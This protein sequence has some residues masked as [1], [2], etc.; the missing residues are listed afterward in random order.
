MSVADF[1]FNPTL[2]AAL[3]GFAVSSVMYGVLSTQVWVYLMQWCSYDKFVKYLVAVIW[4]LETVDQCFIG[5]FVYY[6][7]ITNYGNPLMLLFGKPVWTVVM[8]IVLGSVVGTLVK[9]AFSVRVWRVSG[10]N[11]IITL[12]LLLMTYAQLGLAIYYTYKCFGLSTLEE[13]SQLKLLAS[14]ALGSGVVTDICIAATLCFYLQRLR[15]N[16]SK[17]NAIVRGLTI[18]AIDTGVV[19]SALSIT[20]LVLYHI[21]STDFRF[22]AVYFALSKMYATAFLSS[23]NSR[24]DIAKNLSS[25]ATDILSDYDLRDTGR[26]RTTQG[27]TSF[28]AAELQV[29]I[30]VEQQVDGSSYAIDP[31]NRDHV[32]KQGYAI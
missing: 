32:A 26:Q 16:F 27:N 14:L 30:D 24:T 12:F 19:T 6:Y 23:L 5:H 1:N 22:M 28:F 9:T 4:V 10:H 17:S 29:K 15:T 20:T 2:G 11:Y 21:D 31:W 25:R 18:H 8:Q 7:T 13:V 3:C